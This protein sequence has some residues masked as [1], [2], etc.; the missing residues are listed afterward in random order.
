[1]AIHSKSVLTRAF[2]N[3]QPSSHEITLFTT[4]CSERGFLFLSYAGK[5]STGVF[6]RVSSA[7]TLF[8][9]SSLQLQAMSGIPNCS[10][11]NTY[12]NRADKWQVFTTQVLVL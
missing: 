11:S 2:A 8:S 10:F 6:N 9:V 12:L 4:S 7:W 3:K 5:V 1:M